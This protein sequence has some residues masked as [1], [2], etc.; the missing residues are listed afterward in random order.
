MRGLVEEGMLQ[1]L[2][3]GRAHQGGVINPSRCPEPD[4]GVRIGA[5]DQFGSEAQG[6]G[7]AGGLQTAITIIRGTGRAQH[8]R[9]QQVDKPGIAFGRNIG[10]GRLGFGDNLFGLSHRLHDRCAAIFIAIDTNAEI[11]LA[12][13]R[14]VAQ[15]LEQGQHCIQRLIVQ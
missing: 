13:T 5:G 3:A 10:L 6:A 1:H 2:Q 15:L 9:C 11:D 8:D 7:A 4:S 12:V 14:I